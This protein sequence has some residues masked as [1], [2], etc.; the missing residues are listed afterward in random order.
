[1]G[2]EKTDPAQETQ[3]EQKP[4]TKIASRPDLP[5][6]EAVVSEEKADH[7]KIAHEAAD[8]LAKRDF[9]SLDK[10]AR[11]LRAEK[12]I[13]P[14]GTSALW[15]FYNGV[16][17]VAKHAPDPQWMALLALLNDWIK[18]APDSITPRVALAETLVA[19]AWRARGT[20]WANTVTEEGGRLMEQ[21]LGAAHKILNEARNLHER[22][23]RWW[24][25]AQRVALGEGWDAHTYNTVCDE[26]LALYPENQSI[27]FNKAYELQPRWYGK[28]GEW[29]QFAAAS[30]EKVGGDEGDMLYA[31]IIWHLNEMNIFHNIFPESGIKWDR[32]K[33]SFEVLHKT[34]PDSLQVISE[35]VSLACNAGDWKK[36]RELF[37]V[38]GGR[39]DTV[40]F[41][42]KE[43]FLRYRND[44]YTH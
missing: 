2:C 13:Y 15:S 9:A 4:E 6:P 32:V 27:Y 44:A 11:E 36:A 14:D 12:R 38:I 3:A 41:P 35:F 17:T 23:P 20:G 16:E 8:L 42:R 40:I 33:R 31:R 26:G 39:V 21:R 19:Y 5:I 7:D 28:P 24:T 1:M 22:C 29:E 18:A 30:A 10:R 25:V 43:T 37:T 34:Y